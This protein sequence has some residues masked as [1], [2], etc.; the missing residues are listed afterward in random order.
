MKDP[1][2]FEV[3]AESPSALLEYRSESKVVN[4]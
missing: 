1:R 4:G 2:I 3:P